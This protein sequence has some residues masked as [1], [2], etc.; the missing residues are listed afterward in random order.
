MK[1]FRFSN[2]YHLYEHVRSF[3]TIHYFGHQHD[4]QLI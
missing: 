2:I 3:I 4:K 1:L